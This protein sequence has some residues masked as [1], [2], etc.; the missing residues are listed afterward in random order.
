MK[1]RLPCLFQVQATLQRQWIQF[2]I[3][4]DQRFGRR[5]D[6]RSNNR[7]PNINVAAA[8]AA[9]AAAAEAEAE[10]GSGLPIYI[11]HQEPRNNEVAVNPG[12]EVSE[13]IPMEVVEVVEQET[14]T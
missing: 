8:A 3:Q 9:A 5:N 14:S 6:R 1:T 2:S 7:R 4:C 12:K 10:A 11:C 13:V